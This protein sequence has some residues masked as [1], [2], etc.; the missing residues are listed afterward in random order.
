MVYSV[1]SSGVGIGRVPIKHGMVTV[2]PGATQG[3][4]EKQH[5]YSVLARQLWLDSGLNDKG[6]MSQPKKRS[7][8]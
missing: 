8:S 1:Y 3:T 4:G 2:A 5:R 6:P 7:G